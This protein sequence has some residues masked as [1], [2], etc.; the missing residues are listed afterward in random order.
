MTSIRSITIEAADAAAADHFYRTAFGVGPEIGV[1]T[2]EAPTTGFRGF[3]LS[4]IVS[5]P[6]DADLLLDSALQAGATALKPATKSF[7]GYGGVVQAPDGTIWQVSTSQ[8]KNTGPA[9]REFDRIVLL[10][11]VADVAASK[12]F[13]RDHG[14]KVAK[15][16]GRKYAEFD[17]GIDPVN[18]ALYG[19]R[20]LARTVGVDPDGSGAHRLCIGTDTAGFSDPDGFAWESVPTVENARR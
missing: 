5:Q 2:S 3:T 4:L 15:S 9:V 8:K 14:L 17:T 19:R 12:D 6:A 16:F 10:L 13:Y 7:W 20:G 11:G 1:R 18:L